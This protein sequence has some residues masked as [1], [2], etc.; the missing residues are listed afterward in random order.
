MALRA[1]SEIFCY[2]KYTEVNIMDLYLLR[3]LPHRLNRETQFLNGRIS[4]GWP[5]G[6]NFTGASRENISTALS[7][8]KDNISSIQI[9]IVEMFLHMTIGSIVLTP[10]LSK[11]L[12]HIFETKSLYKYDQSKDNNIEGNPHYIDVKL[13]ASVPR[14]ELPGPLQKSLSGAK[15]LLSN[16]CKHEKS[17]SDYMGLRLKTG[18]E[19]PQ[20]SDQRRMEAINI[21]YGLLHSKDEKICLDAAIALI[22]CPVSLLE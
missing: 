14:E 10:S 16:A 2:L 5:C 20:V 9:S 12:V 22:N 3:A 19:V 7:A 13:I 15:K 11:N 6:I 4:I 18:R 17:F 21:L 8:N 1:K